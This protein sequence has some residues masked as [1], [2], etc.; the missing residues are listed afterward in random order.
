LGELLYPSV[1]KYAKSND[2]APKITGMLIDFE[3][4]EISEI[5]E[6]L[7]SEDNLKDRVIEA[8]ELILKGGELN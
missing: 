2:L 4:F 3:V 6:F 8:E 1:V 7:E 5:I